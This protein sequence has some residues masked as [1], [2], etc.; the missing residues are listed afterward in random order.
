MTKMP[1]FGERV[2]SVGRFGLGQGPEGSFGHIE[3]LL[4]VLPGK[5][6]SS[7]RSE[8]FNPE[9]SEE[10]ISGILKFVAEFCEDYDLADVSFS[11]AIS[12]LELDPI[13]RNEP[14]RASYI[15]LYK[16]LRILNFPT[17]QI[18]EC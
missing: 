5:G 6:K 1:R 13:R 3:I 4:E 8:I 10:M 14:L 2:Q 9:I 15:A 18:F 16:A 7:V 12:K 11:V 17:P